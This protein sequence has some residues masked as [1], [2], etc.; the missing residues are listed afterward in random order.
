MDTESK[1]SNLKEWVSSY[2]DDL[3]RWALAKTSDKESSED[4]VQE[5]FLAAIKAIEK[6]EGN[7]QPKTWLFSILNNKIMDYHRKKFRALTV[8]QSNFL[9]NEDDAELSNELFDRYGTWKDVAKP[10]NWG[11]MDPHLLDNS[12]F[13]EVLERCMKELPGTWF[14]AVQYKYLEEKDAK[15]ICQELEITTSNYWQ[16]IH[17]A[18]LHLRDCIENSWFKQ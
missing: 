3:Y 11:E 14:S 16:M 7:S 10:S 5:T 4:L 9:R 15:L 12:D 8:N 18:K 2:A 17:R 6:F 1:Y 13:T